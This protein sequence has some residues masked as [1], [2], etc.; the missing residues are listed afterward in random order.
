[1]RE[2]EL[3]QGKSILGCIVASLFL[4]AIPAIFI[5][6][7]VDIIYQLP[8]ENNVKPWFFIIGFI[9]SVIAAIVLYLLYSNPVALTVSDEG[10]YIIKDDV[11]IRKED[12]Q[13]IRNTYFTTYFIGDNNQ[14]IHEMPFNNNRLLVNTL[15]DLNYPVIKRDPYRR[16]YLKW[17]RDH[18]AL[19]DYENGQM[20]RIINDFKMEREIEGK[21]KIKF[22]REKGVHVKKRWN[23]YY[24]YK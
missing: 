15:R 2:I 17:H 21:E 16:K 18:P 14:V 6:L 23:G 7:I 1:M 13:Y 10:I 12:I 22:L 4:V 11:F 19:S 3:K 8:D 24:F 5:Y 20:I 9:L